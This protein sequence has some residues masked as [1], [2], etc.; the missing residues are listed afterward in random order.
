METFRYRAADPDGTV[1]EG[2]LGAENEAALAHAVES[3]GSFL[4]SCERLGAARP[5]G[6]KVSG[7]ELFL[8]TRELHILLKGGMPL[9]DALAVL[10]ERGGNPALTDCLAGIGRD[11]ASGTPFAEALAGRPEIFP[12]LYASAVRAGEASG[13]L[14]PVLER[15]AAHLRRVY[16][17]REKLA[18]AAAYP[19]V[20]ALIAAGVT[21]FLVFYVVPVFRIVLADLRLD[22][23]L[24][25]RLL[26]GAAGAAHDHGGLLGAALLLL[27]APASTAGG[28]IALLAALGRLAERLPVTGRVLTDVAS[29]RLASTLSLLLAGGVPALE[30][31]RV[32]RDAADRP[33]LAS[34]LERAMRALSE[35]RDLSSALAAEGCL[36]PTA[37]HLA[38]VGERAGSLPAM[39]DAAAEFLEE[40][41]DH[42]IDLL[43]AL[44]E[45]L[46][47]GTMGLIVAAIVV[48]VFLPVVR[49]ATAF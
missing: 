16:R 22:P 2:V 38:R 25:T 4:V 20:L 13:N 5:R 9:P 26:L 1:R 43:A 15:L 11:L 47:V 39:L 29:A 49:M 35:G 7:R 34:R 17:L 37:A 21:G 30:S 27:L 32:L 6:G 36:D 19:A 24:L 40:E 28:R 41:V 14:L 33:A 42:R 8:L 12:P 45:P 46:L 10:R 31:L 44:A 23:P 48:S 3:T 18:R